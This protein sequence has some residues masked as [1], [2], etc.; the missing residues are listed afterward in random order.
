KFDMYF[1]N[2]QSSN[3][4]RRSEEGNIQLR[5]ILSNDDNF[6]IKRSKK[7]EEIMPRLVKE[8][9]LN[10]GIRWTEDGPKQ[11]DNIAFEFNRI[12]FGTHRP[13]Y[14]CRFEESNKKLCDN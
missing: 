3:V 9:K 13:E 4:I 11:S 7:P 14:R 2:N 6:C 12:E 10:C 1:C 8:K 5:E